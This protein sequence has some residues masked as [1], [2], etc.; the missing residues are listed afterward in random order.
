MTPLVLQSATV[1]PWICML[2]REWE[3]VHVNCPPIQPFISGTLFWTAAKMLNHF[4]SVVHLYNTNHGTSTSDFGFKSRTSV[5]TKGSCENVLFPVFCKPSP[6]AIWLPFLQWYYLPSSQYNKHGHE[7]DLNQKL[8]LSVSIVQRCLD[9]VIQFDPLQK[10]LSLEVQTDQEPRVNLPKYK[11]GGLNLTW[12]SSSPFILNTSAQDR[13]II[14]GLFYNRKSRAQGSEG[15]GCGV[16]YVKYHR[17][18]T[19]L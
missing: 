2:E 4:Y 15:M 18:I 17:P 5:G 12:S 3:R 16:A 9:S 19:V 7:L 6:R 10:G 8:N 14:L 13:T 11:G 1:F